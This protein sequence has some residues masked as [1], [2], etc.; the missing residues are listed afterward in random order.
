[1]SA[2]LD[3][4]A[5]RSFLAIA[6]CGG[7]HRAA[8]ALHL[9]Q[10]AVSQ[11][12]RKLEKALGRPLV[13]RDGRCSR[14]T[15]DGELLL[16][17]ARQLLELHDD[18]LR[19]LGADAARDLVIGSLEHAADQ[20]VPE[21]I[22]SFSEAFPEHRVRFRLDRSAQLAT[23]VDRSVVDVA[24]LS[25]GH[26]GGRSRAA[27]VLPMG[28]FAAPGWQPPADASPLPMVVFDEPCPIRRLAL[29]QLGERGVRFAV[30]AESTTLAGVLAMARAGLGIALLPCT[31]RRPEGLAE[32]PAHLVPPPK[33]AQLR[34]RVRPGAPAELGATAAGAVRAA[35]AKAIP[36]PPLAVA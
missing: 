32:I 22:E 25:G 28:W 19:V 29:G 26:A 35:L 30:V 33:P 36:H 16:T 15:P 5:L 4:V 8:A 21:L 23:S 3:I 14:F 20:L 31:R 2:V 10:S 13:E 11:H 24:V 34:V 27:G 18:T 7:F 17:R 9:T 12:V 6:D 1:M